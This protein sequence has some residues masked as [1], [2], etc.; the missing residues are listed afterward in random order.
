MAES[1]FNI[2]YKSRNESFLYINERSNIKDEW[3]NYSEV[4]HGKYK[5]SILKP[6]N[7]YVENLYQPPSLIEINDNKIILEQS[8]FAEIMLLEKQGQSH[9]TAMEKI[10]MRQFYLSDKELENDPECFNTVYRL[11]IPW[12]LD[13]PGIEIS[14][15]AIDN[16]AFKICSQKITSLDYTNTNRVDPDMIFFRFKKIGDHMIDNEY[17]KILRYTPMFRMI[18]QADDIMVKRVK[19]FYANS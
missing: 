11:F 7:K 12:I 17:G 4:L 8:N 19:E 15:E 14:I 18:F 6:I 16:S 2:W 5:N 3:L 10:H 13:I 9:L 1:D